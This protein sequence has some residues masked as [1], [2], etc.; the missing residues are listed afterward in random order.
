MDNTDIIAILA[1]VLALLLMLS[2]FSLK[3]RVAELESQLA[4]RD[5]YGGSAG[6]TMAAGNRM[7]GIPTPLF[8][9]N[10]EIAP[11]LERR[12]HLLLAEGKKIQAIKV[13]REA[14]N[15]SLKDAKDFIDNLEQGGTFR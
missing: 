9:Q 6:N 15:L 7:A 8:V 12:L 3:K 2:V 13:M 1:L 4:Q 5:A 14:R 10:P 11:D